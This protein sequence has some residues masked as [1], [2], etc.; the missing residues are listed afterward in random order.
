MQDMALFGKLDCYFFQVGVAE[1]F[2]NKI[3]WDGIP[4]FNLVFTESPSE[5]NLSFVLSPSLK[6]FYHS[7][8]YNEKNFL[9]WMLLLLLFNSSLSVKCQKHVRDTGFVISW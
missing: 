9:E 5:K 7:F 1:T 4:H 8:E 3:A 2:Q 6:M